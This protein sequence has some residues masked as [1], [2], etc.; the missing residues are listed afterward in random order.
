MPVLNLFRPKRQI[1]TVALMIAD[2]LGV[3]S[4]SRPGVFAAAIRAPLREN[5][6]CLGFVGVSEVV[7][8]IGEN[9]A[10]KLA[11]ELRAK[12]PHSV[13]HLPDTLEIVATALWALA[14]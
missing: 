14:N 6:D 13:D 4:A 5:G 2:P 3:N 9:V 12:P 10:A 11:S 8:K 7:G 1:A